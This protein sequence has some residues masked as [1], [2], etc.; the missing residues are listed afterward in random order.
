VECKKG[1]ELDPNDATAHQRYA[2]VSPGWVGS[3]EEGMAE[4]KQARQLDPLS[5]IIAH[6]VGDL[7][8]FN[9][10]Y[11]EAIADGQRLATENPTFARAH[12]CLQTSTRSRACTSKW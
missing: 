3:R 7:Q 8:L 12:W 1:F 9:R 6:E 2:E 11:D 4:I 10:R 5:L